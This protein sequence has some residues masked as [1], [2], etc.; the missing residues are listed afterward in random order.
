MAQPVVAPNPFGQS[1]N[2]TIQTNARQPGY[3]I[4]KI[5]R[6]GFLLILGFKDGFRERERF[7][8]LRPDAKAGVAGGREWGQQTNGN[9]S[10]DRRS[11][12]F[13]E[14]IDATHRVSSEA[15]PQAKLKLPRVERC[16]WLTERCIRRCSRSERVVRH[17]KIRAIEKIEAF[18]QHVESKPFS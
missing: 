2:M 9:G 1:V 6:S 13:P 16:G 14:N 8:H 18:G 3:M 7:R 12:S 15:Q 17:A 11:L 4:G 5:S 10:Q